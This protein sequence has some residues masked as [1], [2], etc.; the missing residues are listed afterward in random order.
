MFDSPNRERLAY[1]YALDAFTW[2]F[3]FPFSDG[4]YEL[5]WLQSYCTATFT[6]DVNG[7]Q[8]FFRYGSDANECEPGW[9]IEAI[10]SAFVDS[11]AGTLRIS[12]GAP[13]FAFDYASHRSAEV[14]FAFI[15]P[16]NDTASLT[17]DDVELQA[18]RLRVSRPIAGTGTGYSDTCSFFGQD[19][20]GLAGLAPQ[21]LVSPSNGGEGRLKVFFND[22]IQGAESQVFERRDVEEDT[23]FVCSDTPAGTYDLYGAI[24]DGRG[25]KLPF[26]LTVEILEERV[27]GG[28]IE[29]SMTSTSDSDGDGV[30]DDDDAFPSDPA[31]SVDTDG[32]GSPDNW[33]PG[34]TSDQI[35]ASTLT[36]D[37]FPDDKFESVDSDSDG[38]GANVDVDD[39][40]SSVGYQSFAS[41]LSG[42]SDPALQAC[43]QNQYPSATS[44]ADVG[45]I[46]CEYP[47]SEADRITNIQG[48]DA[49]KLIQ[50]F[51]ISGGAFSDL[52]PLAP[53]GETYQSIY[54]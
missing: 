4:S 46:Y 50:S 49:F 44:I 33:N 22:V 34:A 16:V 54:V 51:Y 48:V 38:I 23:I 27:S 13:Y 36:L 1:Y 30:P 31:T 9:D 35:A 6:V 43:L 42:I 32:D 5:S 45:D 29:W 37:A 25:G 14:I 2:A 21:L 28:S 7:D 40:D 18:N 10:K 53:A 3:P 47:E 8:R 17:V 12:G 26:D 15:G 11:A 19:A 41:A 24:L 39:N 20:T 52:T